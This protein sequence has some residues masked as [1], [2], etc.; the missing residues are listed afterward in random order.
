[1]HSVKSK[2]KLKR[3]IGYIMGWVRASTKIC[4]FSINLVFD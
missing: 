4:E 1:M 2:S 3:I